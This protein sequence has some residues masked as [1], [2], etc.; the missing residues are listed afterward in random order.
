MPFQ[1][2]ADFRGPQL[3][4]VARWVA[5]RP[6]RVL[7][8]ALIGAAARAVVLSAEGA[9]S[10]EL[11][12]SPAEAL[13]LLKLLWHCLLRYGQPPGEGEESSEA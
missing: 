5:Q 4:R 8:P 13:Q 2:P 3:P 1:V 10:A 9:L 12:C 7:T 6:P 11:E